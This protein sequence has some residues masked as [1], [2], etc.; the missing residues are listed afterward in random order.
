MKLP[1]T[2]NM[3]SELIALP[4]ISCSNPQYDQSNEAIINL[5][6]EWCGSLGFHCITAP[7]PDH[8]GKYNLQATMGSGDDGLLLAGHVDT[9]P[10]DL[11][12]WQ[13]DP[14]KLT[15]KDGRLYGLGTSDMKSFFA[16]TLTAVKQLLSK[17]IVFKQPVTILATANEESNMAGARALTAKPPARCALIGEP[18]GLKPIRMH[19][20]ILMEA[21]HIRGRSAHSSNPDWGNSALEGMYRVIGDL[22]QWR[23]LLQAEHTH[24]SFTVPVPTLNLGHIQGGDSPNRICADCEL[25][26]DL[27]PLPGMDISDLRSTLHQRI[28]RCLRNSGLEIEFTPLFEGIPAMETPADADIVLTTERLTRHAAGAV[29]YGTEAPY[30]QALGMETIIL[31]PGDIDQAHQPDEFIDMERLQPMIDILSELIVHYCAQ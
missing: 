13:F 5:L 24:P 14:F 22:L 9:V 16:L 19:K 28:N 17:N 8:Q 2:L 7:V 4:S 6:A 27:R 15:E 25:H 10:Y 1:S 18:T 20:G 23:E 21:I 26:I 29:A 31:G 11:D 12:R 3:I 30:F